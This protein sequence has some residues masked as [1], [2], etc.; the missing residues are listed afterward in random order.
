[1]L[2]LSRRYAAQAE[3]YAMEEAARSPSRVEQPK[4]PLATAKRMRGIREPCGKGEAEWSLGA[5]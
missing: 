4:A 1:M 5:R 2:S 3:H